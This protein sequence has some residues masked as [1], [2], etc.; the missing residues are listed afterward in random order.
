[1]VVLVWPISRLH[2]PAGVLGANKKNC[3]SSRNIYQ[4]SKRLDQ[5]K[6]LVKT[7]RMVTAFKV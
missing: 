1:M 6:A 3:I 4:F 5:M 2:A 7:R